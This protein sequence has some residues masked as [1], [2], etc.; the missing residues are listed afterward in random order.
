M[1]FTGQMNGLEHEDLI[2]FYKILNKKLGWVP[3]IDVKVD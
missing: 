3:D 1:M 2:D